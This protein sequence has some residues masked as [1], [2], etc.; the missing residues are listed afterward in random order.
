MAVPVKN[1]EKDL[2]LKILYEEEIPV[3]YHKNRTVHTLI[4]KK[5]AKEDMLF[6]SER[7]VNKLKARDKIDLMFDYRGKAIVFNVQILHIKEREVSCSIPDFFY[8][9]LDRSY[10][11]VSTPE[12]MEVQFTFMGDRYRLSFPKVPEYDPEDLTRFFK[13]SD[14]KNFSTLVDQMAGWIRKHASG[15]KLV[16]FKD[17]KP[18]TV[19]ELIISE[20]GKVLFLPSPQDGFPKEDPFPR[21][22]I[23]TEDIFKRYLEGTGTRQP[24]VDGTCARF[25]RDKAFS[26]ILSD[27]W[28]PIL[29]LEY[30]IGYIHVWV[31]AEGKPPLDFPKINTLNQLA[32]V[33]AYSLKLNGYFEKGKVKNN[34]EGKIIDISASGL[35]F[36]YPFSN[37]SSA[38]KSESRLLVKIMTPS[39]SISAE[40]VIMRRFKDKSFG[41][42]GCQFDNMEFDDL[43]YLFE[44]IYGK[45]HTDFDVN[46]LIG[47]V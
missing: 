17:V 45:P 9:N 14:I 38:L 36:A 22:K 32:K 28:I 13:D 15:Y 6:Y 19:E 25:I 30:V 18:S 47:Q 10:S 7:P 31:N 5:P 23:I 40:A 12:Q 8:K 27:A 11:R 21:K 39:R 42:Y 46:L 24:L 26:G 4:L 3:I 34:F 2:M 43:S 29:F 16:I 35:L 41:Y 1:I 37:L 44:Y 20:T 33:L